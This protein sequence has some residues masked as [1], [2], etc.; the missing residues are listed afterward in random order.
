M[1]ERMLSNWGKLMILR[2]P[3]IWHLAC[4]MS[5]RFFHSGFNVHMLLTGT[6]GIPTV[7]IYLLLYGRRN[8]II[9]SPTGILVNLQL[10]QHGQLSSGPLYS[11]FCVYL[12]R[13]YS[14]GPR[15]R[16]AVGRILSEGEEEADEGLLKRCEGSGFN[17]FS[18]PEATHVVTTSL[19]HRTVFSVPLGV[20]RVYPK[21]ERYIKVP[22]DPF[23]FS[24][25]WYYCLHHIYFSK[26]KF[27][28]T[29][30]AL[31]LMQMINIEPS[32]LHMIWI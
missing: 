17:V 20:G 28:L 3:Q 29:Q 7:L 12:L 2:F 27:V 13:L 21:L 9:W 8:D 25:Q 23:L 26:F 16:Y 22:T 11:P 4:F 14:Q 18:F 32:A 5:S 1:E 31:I 15:C 6:L 30:V 10:N 19:P 24:A